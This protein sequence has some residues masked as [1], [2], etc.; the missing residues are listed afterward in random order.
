MSATMSDS[1]SPPITTAVPL[2]TRRRLARSAKNG[3]RPTLAN[4]APHAFLAGFIYPALANFDKATEEARKGMEIAPEQWVFYF[5][6]GV[7]S[8]YAGRPNHTEEALRQRVR[9]QDRDCEIVGSAI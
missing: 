5:E 1:L 7:N 2:E 4:I 3:Q 9:T 6:L 8:L